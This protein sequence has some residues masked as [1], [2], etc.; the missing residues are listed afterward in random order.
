MSMPKSTGGTPPARRT[1]LERWRSRAAAERRRAAAQREF[2]RLQ[3]EVRRK[4]RSVRRDGRT[5]ALVLRARL[6]QS[7]VRRLTHPV[8]RARTGCEERQI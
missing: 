6:A 5:A 3:R 4:V 7:A 1:L 2:N 8:A